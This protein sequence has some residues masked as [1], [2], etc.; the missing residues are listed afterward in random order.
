MQMKNL[1]LTFLLFVGIS[2]TIKP[3]EVSKNT[4]TEIAAL[5]TQGFG[6]PFLI[7][8]HAAW[9]LFTYDRYDEDPEGQ[10]N[11]IRILMLLASV[12]VG[13]HYGYKIYKL[14]IS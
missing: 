3:V 5:S 4:L 1:F 7:C 11:E 12:P 2:S 10:A 6:I 8:A 13:A 9:C 14:L